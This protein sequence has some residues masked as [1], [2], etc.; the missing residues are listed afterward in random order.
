V[1]RLRILFY[2]QAHQDVINAFR[3]FGRP[4]LIALLSICTLSCSG[5]ICDCHP[6][7]STSRDFRHDEKHVPLPSNAP[8]ETSVTQILTW[9]AGPNPTN[10]TPRSGRELT[11][12]HIATAFLQNARIVSFDCDV[13]AELSEVAS[14]SAPR[15][16]VETPS[17][18]E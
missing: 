5:G 14:K 8:I 7:A 15:V 16:I 6:T 1:V 11:L 10:T 3:N 9:P 18:R 12:Y 17:D 2:V 13:H 4:S